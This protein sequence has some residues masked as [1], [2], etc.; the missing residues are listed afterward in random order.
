MT[1]RCRQAGAQSVELVVESLLGHL[2]VSDQPTPMTDGAAERIHRHF[3][4][5]SPARALTG[6]VRQSGAITIVGLEPTR[7]Q[8]HARGLGL[9]G[10]EHPHRARMQPL[11]LDRPRTMQAAGGLDRDHRPFGRRVSPEQP[12]QPN[13]PLTRHRQ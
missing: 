7:A 5:A 10:S 1:R 3:L 2:A 6:Q 12:F 13:D 11:E 8:L 4:G 9:R